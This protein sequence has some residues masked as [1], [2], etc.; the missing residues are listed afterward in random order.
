MRSRFLIVLA[1]IVALV[2]VPSFV[3]ASGQQQGGGGEI[4]INWPSI[5]VG[6]DAKAPAIDALVEEFNQAN[7]GKIKVVVEPNPDYDGYRDKINAAIAA[8]Q[9]PDIFIFNPDPTTFQYYEGDL[10]MDFTKDLNGAW[11]KQFVPGTVKGATKNGVTKSIPFEVGV[12]PI[13]YNQDLFDKAGIKEFPKTFDQ[14]WKDADRLKAAGIVPASQMTG[15]SNAWTSMLWYSH[16]LASIGGQDVWDKPLTDPQYV[17][18]ARIMQRMF[19]EYTTKDAVGADAGVSGGHYLAGR[20][21]MFINGPWYIGRIRDEA[22]EVYKATKLTPAPQVKGGKYGAQIAFPLSNLAA[23]ST[24]DPARR[25]AVVKFLKWLT[26]P[27]NVAKISE[28]AGSLFAIKYEVDRTNIDPL[29]LQFIDALNNAS[30]AVSHFQAN[31]PVDVTAELG[32]GFGAMA[33]GR[34]TPEEFVKQLQAVANN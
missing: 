26:K 15:G 20:T 29:Q 9:V 33:L 7:E 4:V 5:W 2:L 17:E 19:Q 6:Q 1:A 23:A 12:T 25:A 24:D 18:A 30:F 34:M 14:F 21:A 22:P 16:I 28:S 8:G 32:Q 13:W 11:G 27:E 3:F 31:F 10:L